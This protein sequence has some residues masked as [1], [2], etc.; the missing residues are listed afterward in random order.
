MLQFR[1][2]VGSKVDKMLN[3][4]NFRQTFVPRACKLGQETHDVFPYGLFP[5]V[6]MVVL[7]PLFYIHVGFLGAVLVRT[8]ENF[9]Q[10]LSPC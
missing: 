3:G 7:S 1:T 8:V 10:S 5:A 9:L 4:G 2:E 6:D